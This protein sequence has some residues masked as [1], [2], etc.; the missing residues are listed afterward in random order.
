M[1]SISAQFSACCIAWCLLNSTILGDTSENDKLRNRLTQFYMAVQMGQTEKAAQFVIESSRK[2]FSSGGQSKILGFD[3]AAITLEEDQKSAMVRMTFKMMMPGMPQVFDVPD[4]SRWRLESG[5]W[6]L[7]P[8]NPPQTYADKQK[9]YYFDKLAARNKKGSTAPPAEVKFEKDLID[10]GTQAKGKVIQIKFPF[11]NIS[12]QSIRLE[13]VY[14]PTLFLKD[15]TRQTEFKPGEKGEV[16]IELDTASLFRGFDQ[17]FFVEFQPIKE[18]VRLRVRG[19]V[20]DAKD[21]EAA[22]TK[23]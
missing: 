4:T 14:I 7:D 9:E 18:M 6:Y 12:K 23:K 22:E 21:V 10:V 16:A 8:S 17:T 20:F 13:K 11:T 2:S 5:E 19:K 1:R 3:I 15:I